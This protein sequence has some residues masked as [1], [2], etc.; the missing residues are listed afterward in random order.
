ME[1]F[2]LY[3][4]QEFIMKRLAESY[5]KQPMLL[6]NAK[7]QTKKIMQ[8][9]KLIM[10]TELLMAKKR[11]ESYNNFQSRRIVNVIKGNYGEKHKG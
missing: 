8:K 2:N 4:E 3:K 6:H 5:R 1:K 10:E 9:K 7:S 11:L